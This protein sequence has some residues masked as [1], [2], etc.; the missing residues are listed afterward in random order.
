MSDFGLKIAFS[1]NSVAVVGG[2]DRPQ[3]IGRSVLMNIRQSGFRGPVGWVSPKSVADTGVTAARK[4]TDIPFV[5]ELLV[6]T[7]PPNAT[8]EVL[9]SAGRAGVRGAVIISAGFGPP[10]SRLREDI[11][12]IVRRTGLRIIGPN[13]LG[14]IMP[15]S[16]LNASFA[17][18]NPGSGNLAL[19]SQSGAIAA[20]MIDW[21]RQ[22]SIGFSGIVS[23]GDQIDVDTADCI[24][25]FAKDPATHAILLYI[26]SIGDARKFM[27]AA[28]AAARVKPVVVL[29]SGRMAEGA[30]AA[31]TH[32]GALAG[33]DA[34]YDAAFR[35]AGLL[36]VFDSRELF[37]CAE[38]LSRVPSLAGDRLAIL[39]N[40]GGLG[41]LALD[42]LSELGGK[43]A[44][45]SESCFAAL[46]SVLPKSWSRS[47]PI[48]IVGDADPAR[49]AR[50]L[51][52]LLADT[53][54][55]AILVMNV[56]TALAHPAETATV[57]A[58]TVEEHRQRPGGCKAVLASW[59]GADPDVTERLSA[60][61]IPNY[62]TEDDAVRGF[63]HLVRH[64]ANI[65]SLMETPPG[66][67]SAFVPKT[68][69]VRKI[70]ADALREGRTWLTALEVGSVLA[71]YDIQSPPVL[72]A[73]DPA[74][75]GRIVRP[76]LEGSRTVAVKISSR[77]IVH[78][79]EVGGVVLN[80]ASV[81]AVEEA[82]RDVI[83]RA[84]RLRPDAYIDGVMIQPMVMRQKARELIAGIA[85][86]PIFGPVIVF[87]RGGTAV[88]VI[89]DKAIGLPPLD[90]R[91][92][93]ELIR[94]TRVSRLLPAYRDVPAVAPGVVQTLLVKLSQ[95]TA[96]VSEIRELDLNPILAD[97]SG[98]VAVDARISI[99]QARR[100]FYGK[101]NAHFAIKPYPVEWERQLVLNQGWTISVR[102]IR[103][104][105]EPALHALLERVTPE[106]LRLRFFAPMK[107]FSHEF[108]ARLTQLDYARA[109]AFAAFDE[110][111][112]LVG[113]ARLH[114][115][116]MYEQAEYAILLRSD[117]K[118]R[119][120]GW[121]LM[122]MLIEYATKEGLKRISGEVLQENEVMLRMCR[123]LGFDVRPNK[124]DSSTCDVTLELRADLT[125][126]G[127]SK[128]HADSG[129]CAAS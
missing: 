22:R 39:T 2:S 8:P 119:G 70:V 89:D 69:S 31:A 102:P 15:G 105:D 72:L 44:A 42:R 28:R 88:E 29:K 73:E 64:R 5:P 124:E 91:L 107:Q 33:V 34:V 76:L 30:R 18:S 24:D 84:K 10:D 78:K 80:L 6:I 121:A 11:R 46:D 71:A 114:S 21:A 36:R 79:S 90:L 63:M 26:E 116:S 126:G 14:L 41:V 99:G 37:D 118:G 66:M 23:L 13:C 61:G 75:A 35:R 59:A 92:A 103:P 106:D 20:A 111:S 97:E 17:G 112:D 16:R 51:S 3:S 96:D 38:T 57:V 122:Q 47:N 56:S 108:I 32:T 67:P 113:V 87:G 62:P 95:L 7:A 50:A 60:A 98:I 129:K 58:Q 43:R 54:N 83:A 125:N 101:G 45:L 82:T 115:D 85:T 12:S 109:M 86:D 127:C 120:L 74:A 40:G 53:S 27:S 110:R 100:A 117:L 1:P 48:D 94:Q 65:Q 55:D 52:A 81:A 9:Q 77:D 4:L 49:Y 19:I 68:G 25:Y 123:Q 93:D 128:N 104:E